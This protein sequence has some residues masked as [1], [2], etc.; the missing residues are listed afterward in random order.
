[1]LHCD[2]SSHWQIQRKR[3]ATNIYARRVEAPAP[4]KRVVTA[5]RIAWHD[6]MAAAG[7]PTSKDPIRPADYLYLEQRAS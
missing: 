1:M 2:P 3:P 5:N 6:R 4:G 7:Q